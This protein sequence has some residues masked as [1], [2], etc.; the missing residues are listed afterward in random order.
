MRFSPPIQQISK[1]TVKT[2][3]K[4]PFLCINNNNVDG[5]SCHDCFHWKCDFF[6]RS[7]YM[8]EKKTKQQQFRVQQLDSFKSIRAQK[9]EILSRL[10]GKWNTI[11]FLPAPLSYL[12]LNWLRWSTG[13][14]NEN[15]IKVKLPVVYKQV[16]TRLFVCLYNCS[17]QSKSIRGTDVQNRVFFFFCQF[18]LMKITN[19]GRGGSNKMAFER[20]IRNGNRHQGRVVKFVET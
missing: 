6:F 5:E 20:E 13:A 16:G 4:S 15:D 17:T 18:R 8:R 9:Y 11:F 7:I 14:T 3:I 19:G 12:S 2:G 1:Y 10:F